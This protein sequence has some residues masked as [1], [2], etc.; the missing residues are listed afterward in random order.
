MTNHAGRQTNKS[1]WRSTAMRGEDGISLDKKSRLF[2][3]VRCV[4]VPAGCY[5]C[6][7]N[8][9]DP[10]C[11][12]WKCVCRKNISSRSWRTA[13]TPASSSCAPRA[14]DTDVER[15]GMAPVLYPCCIPRQRLSSILLKTTV[16]PT[17]TRRN[18][19]MHHSGSTS[20]YQLKREMKPDK[21]VKGPVWQ[22]DED[23]ISLGKNGVHA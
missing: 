21:P 13:L 10:A 2:A 16:T 12:R 17:S 11:G 6:H 9:K 18:G 1:H 4:H 15:V 20:P 5:R 19:G 22:T 7:Q 3:V 8:K 23:E 14:L